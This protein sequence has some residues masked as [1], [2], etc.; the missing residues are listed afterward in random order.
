MITFSLTG[1]IDP[2]EPTRHPLHSP[3]IDLN[4][5]IIVPFD[6]LRLI[7]AGNNVATKLS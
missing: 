2:P 5:S 7:K 1:D 4:K 3:N 6:D